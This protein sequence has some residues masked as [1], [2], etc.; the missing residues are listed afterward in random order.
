M[1][2][3]RMGIVIAIAAMLLLGSN[4]NDIADMASDKARAVV[5]VVN[6]MKD[7]SNNDGTNLG[8]GFIID[9]NI[10]VT[11]HHVIADSIGLKIKGKNS[12]K[13]Y[14]AT[15]IASD[16]FSDLAIIKIA[17]WD[18]FVLTNN[19]GMLRFGSSRDLK[20]GS[21]VWSIGHPW[22]LEW[23]VSQ[24]VVSSPS[25]RIDGNLNFLIQTDTKIYQGNSGGP[26]L[27]ENGNVIGVNDKMLAQTGG[28][29]GLAIPSDLASRI[30]E[31]LR[32]TGKARWS[33][34]GVKMGYTD[35]SKN[36]KVKEISSGSA[37]AKA[38]MEVDDIILSI[39][40]SQTSVL[41]TQVNS[42]DQLL[43]EMAVINPGESITL[44]IKRDNQ[45]ST[46]LVYPDLKTSDE[47]MPKDDRP[48]SR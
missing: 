31:D 20:L 36:V 27:D 43:D 41:G 39:T 4:Q 32:K 46:I 12:E 14:D 2:F 24:G 22:G 38:G 15:V 35:D 42:T 19:S 21:K 13:L 26:L 11:N 34:I 3:L 29:F 9:D 5:M 45:L 44:F 33:V 28:S 8:T 37:A 18:D 47:L 25:R 17:N 10:I 16:R 23:S 1:L 6:T 48:G 40:T 7:K 30:I